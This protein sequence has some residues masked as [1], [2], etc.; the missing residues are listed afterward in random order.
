ML[1]ILMLSDVLYSFTECC[2]AECSYTEFHGIHPYVHQQVKMVLFATI[3]INDIQ[4]KH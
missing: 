3:S 4:H 2:Y 1:T